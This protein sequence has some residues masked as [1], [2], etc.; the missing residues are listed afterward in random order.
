M[1]LDA[2]IEN[3]MKDDKKTSFAIKAIDIQNKLDGVYE[4]QSEQI[5]DGDIIIE[6]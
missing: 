5:N 1:R 3:A 2:I 4:K 6:F